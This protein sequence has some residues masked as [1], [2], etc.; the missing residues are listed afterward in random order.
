MVRC[1]GMGP[2][3]N[4]WTTGSPQPDTAPRRLTQQPQVLAGGPSA[5][6]GAA[7][8]RTGAR[9]PSRTTG[10]L[11]ECTVYYPQNAIEHAR[12]A[13]FNVMMTSVP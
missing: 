13:S 5:T 9:A 3:A 8:A 11:E 2:N 1:V 12:C 4:G 7:R 10:S 6:R